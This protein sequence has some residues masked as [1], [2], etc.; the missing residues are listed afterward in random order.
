LAEHAEQAGNPA[1]DAGTPVMTA[2][3]DMRVRQ[4]IAEVGADPTRLLDVA[5]A[6]QKRFGFVSAESI[7]LIAEGLGLHAVEVED[8]VSFYAFLD[9]VPR[10]EFRIRLS[11]TPISLMKGAGAIAAAFEAALGISM[12]E[13]TPD[14]K[15]TLQWT[16]DIGMA[17]Q[18]PAALLNSTVMTGWISLSRNPAV[19]A[20]PAV[21]APRCLSKAWRRSWLAAPRGPICGHWKRWLTRFPA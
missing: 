14:G 15:F 12:G 19:G 21:S 11:K 2:S 3:L 6:V 1:P 8:T 16:N 9:R 5:L 17:D 10:G 13:T 4:F 18:E 7:A 20:R